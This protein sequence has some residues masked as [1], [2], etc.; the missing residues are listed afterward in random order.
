VEKIEARE[1]IERGILEGRLSKD[2][3][4]MSS[5]T[6]RFRNYLGECQHGDGTNTKIRASFDR[7]RLACRVAEWKKWPDCMNV[8]Q[9]CYSG[10]ENVRHFVSKCAAYTEERRTLTDSIRCRL[11][12]DG[13]DEGPRLLNSI[14]WDNAESIYDLVL[15]M[16]YIPMNTR[17]RSKLNR[18]CVN[19]LNSIKKKRD[20]ASTEADRI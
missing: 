4:F 8:C 11:T 14:A 15:E 2:V 6:L 19:Y 16:E 9:M 5:D 10:D 1:G 13:D 12:E 7:L 18:P 17:M 20:E 3:A